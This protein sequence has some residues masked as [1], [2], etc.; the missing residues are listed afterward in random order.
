MAWAALQLQQY[1]LATHH[2]IAQGALLLPLIGGE[3]RCIVSVS[4]SS[5]AQLSCFLFP[6][7]NLLHVPSNTFIMLNGNRA[8]KT[9]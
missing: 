3:L 1:P 7:L 9:H 4:M 8:T 2:D 5:T 6:L